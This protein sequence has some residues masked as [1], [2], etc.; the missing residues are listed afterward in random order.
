MKLFISWSN[1]HAQA[2]AETLRDWLKDVIHALEPF[3]S[4]LDVAKGERGLAV[5]ARELEGSSHGII[6]VNRANQ[7]APWLNFEA[8][9]ISKQVDKSRVFPVLI[10][11]P[12]SDLKGPLRGFQYTEL[13]SEADML[14]LIESIWETCPDSNIDL[15][16]LQRNFSR[17]WP[18]LLESLKEIRQ[19]PSIESEPGQEA[20]SDADKLDEL[21]GLARQ[22]Q[23]RIESLESGILL[24]QSTRRR[25]REKSAVDALTTNP[26]I[27][28]ILRTIR[29]IKHRLTEEC[30]EPIELDTKQQGRIVALIPSGVR[31]GTETARV[32][33]E[34]ARS[35]G[36]KLQFHR[37]QIK[38]T[39]AQ[40]EP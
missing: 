22:N 10:D 23:R 27:D 17:L 35:N 33:S 2:V 8:G 14:R 28:D 32:L 6:C 4:S 11:L 24:G 38:S 16:Q 31:V 34:L 36:L 15:T 7:S 25:Q 5:I 40:R 9:A 30:G 18:E 12:G 39:D 1:P 21:L 3:V 37:T 29:E 26:D 20:R 19:T 13:F